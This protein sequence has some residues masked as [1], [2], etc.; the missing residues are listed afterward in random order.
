[1]T[2]QACP[3]CG[4]TQ[5]ELVFSWDE[6]PAGETPFPLP[7]GRAYAREFRRCADCDLFIG[8]HGLGG[9]GF[10][11][12]EYVDVTYG[13]RMAETYDRIRALPPGQS[14]NESRVQRILTELGR[15]GSVLDVGAGLG[16]F[17][18]RMR[19]AGWQVTALDPDPRAVEHLRS[20]VR[21]EAI[22]AD[23]FQAEDVGCFDLV[24]FNKVLEHVENPVAML[25]RAL[26]HLRPGG[27]VYVEVPDGDGAAADGP[28]REEFFIEHL[29]AFGVDSLR[30]VAGHAGFDA[31]R[32]EAVRDP[33]G[34]YTLFAFLRPRDTASP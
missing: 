26:A 15:E 12:G 2:T 5:L 24:T 13:D 6:P 14:D 1:M 25:G 20:H 33:S 29:Y 19:E 8:V 11:G 31:L 17:P 4:S 34:K 10:Y 16:V 30:L 27:I 3:L 23:F 28:H 7:P 22:C 21:V 9:E 32:V 18:A